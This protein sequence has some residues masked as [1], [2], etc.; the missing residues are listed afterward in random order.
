MKN[1]RKSY[2]AYIA[3]AI[4]ICALAKQCVRQPPHQL[5]E[6]PRTYYHTPS[7]SPSPD[8]PFRE[9][10]SCPLPQK[11]TSPTSGNELDPLNRPNMTLDGDKGINPAEID[12]T[13]YDLMY[14]DPDL[15]DFIAD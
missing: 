5:L 12:P 13:E 3:A 9:D 8:T 11:E 4:V 7:G 14:E 6:E 10:Q 2:L 15:Y 1:K